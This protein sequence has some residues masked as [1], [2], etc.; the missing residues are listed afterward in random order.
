[1]E[2]IEENIEEPQVELATEPIV[3]RRL[4]RIETTAMASNDMPPN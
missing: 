1:M 2:K 3:I 4:D